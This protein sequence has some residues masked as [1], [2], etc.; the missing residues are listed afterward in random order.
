M[1]EFNNTVRK[2]FNSFRESVMGLVACELDPMTI[3]GLLWLGVI[4]LVLVLGSS[5]LRAFDKRRPMGG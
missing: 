2:L 3:M 4:G 5:L 1:S